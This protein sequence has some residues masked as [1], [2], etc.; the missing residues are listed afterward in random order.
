M[1]EPHPGPVRI[2]RLEQHPRL[3][4]MIGAN[5]PRL[6]PSHQKPD[7]FRLF[8]LEKFDVTCIGKKCKMFTLNRERFG[9]R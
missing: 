2:K 8:V 7:L 9:V 3:D 6:V 4:V 1:Y 5:L